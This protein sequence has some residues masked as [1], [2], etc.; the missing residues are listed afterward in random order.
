M[1]ASKK[2]FLPK[3]YSIKQKSIVFAFILCVTVI[4]YYSWLPNPGFETETYLPFWL[5]SWSNTYFNLRTAIP[6]IPLGYLTEAWLSIPNKN[7]V[8]KSSLWFRIKTILIATIVVCLAEGGQYFIKNRNPDS[9][10]IVFGLLGSVT[11][12]ICYYLIQK[13]NLLI[14]KNAEQI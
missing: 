6:F 14:T 7:F 11:G 4:F 9:L 8:S 13:I 2:V 3:K 10:D 1:I 12:S 5:R